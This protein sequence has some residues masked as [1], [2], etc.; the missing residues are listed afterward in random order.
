MKAEELGYEG[1]PLSQNHGK[2]D[3]STGGKMKKRVNK[4]NSVENRERKLERNRYTS[5]RTRTMTARANQDRCVIA[6]LASTQT[7]TKS[8]F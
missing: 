2:V 3:Q 6:F 4:A 8:F 7:L 1:L 5:P